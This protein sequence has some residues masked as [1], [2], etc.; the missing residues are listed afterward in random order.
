VQ[1]SKATDLGAMETLVEQLASVLD[2]AG[3]LR[4]VRSV[5]DRDR[6][7]ADTCRWYCLGRTRPAF[8]RLDVH[9][10]Y[11][12][13]IIIIITITVVDLHSAM[14]S[15]DTEAPVIVQDG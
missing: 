8:E 1:L 4:P 11:S 12:V 14:E 2:M 15:A 5:A 6:I 3:S 10:V 7:V 9:V 13:V